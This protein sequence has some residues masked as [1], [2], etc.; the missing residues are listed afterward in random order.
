MASSR[1]SESS[2]N[3]ATRTID[4]AFRIVPTP[5]VI[6]RVGV[7][8]NRDVEPSTSHRP[9]SSDSRVHL[10]AVDKVNRS[11]FYTCSGCRD[12]TLVR[13]RRGDLNLC[14][15]FGIEGRLAETSGIMRLLQPADT[16]DSD[17]YRSKSPDAIFRS[18]AERHPG[19]TRTRQ[20]PAGTPKPPVGASNQHRDET[21]AADAV[22]TFEPDCNVCTVFE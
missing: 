16:I 13:C 12:Q 20:S 9:F 21:R 3:H 15:L 7:P 10:V 2:A 14:C 22:Q 6:E 1:R 18:L 5:C 19:A 11:G 8:K 17:R 4:V